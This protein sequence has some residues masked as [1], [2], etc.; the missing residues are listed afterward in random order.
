VRRLIQADPARLFEAWTNPAQ[1]RAWW[2]PRG[3]RCTG[4]QIDARVGGC[5]RI[6]NALPDGRVV[7]ISGEF[8]VVEPPT[9]LE[10]TWAVEPPIGTAW[11]ERVSVRFEARGR[12]T[13]VV[14]THEQIPDARTRDEHENGWTGCL[15]GLAAFLGQRRLGPSGAS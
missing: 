8:L 2:G 6:D 14:V 3:V 13:E 12:D 15:D 11:P 10:F 9:R 4:A 5:Y 7:V 1:L